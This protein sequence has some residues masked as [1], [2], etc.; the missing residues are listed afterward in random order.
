MGSGVVNGA[1]WGNRSEDDKARTPG[2]KTLVK[3]V[4]LVLERHLNL[5]YVC[6]LNTIITALVSAVLLCNTRRVSYKLRLRTEPSEAHVQN[7]LLY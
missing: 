6:P 4:S 7:S 2:G 3:R 5:R 1:D